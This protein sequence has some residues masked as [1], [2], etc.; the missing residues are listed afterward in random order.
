MMKRII[1]LGAS[2][3]TLALPIIVEMLRAACGP[4]ELLAAH[5]HG[6]SFGMGSRL[7]CR[8]LPSIRSCRLWRDL[9]RREPPAQRPW[10]LVTDVGNDLLYG[11]SPPQIRDWVATCLDRLE[12]Q[13]ADV[14]L[15]TLPMHSV[16]RLGRVRFG[17]T[18]ALFF[19][20]A[21]LAWDRM[22]ALA[23][24][25]DEGLR[26]LASERGVRTLAP[27]PE[28]YGFDP[29]H[30]RRRMRRRAWSHLLALE[31]SPARAV[32]ARRWGFATAVRIRLAR[33]AVRTVCGV[34]Q[35]AV[36]PVLCLPD[37]TTI[38]LY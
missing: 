30:I 37:G 1:L 4:V 35:Q 3:I 13:E 17:L 19:P 12:T 18:R 31:S 36:Q 16:L 7:L 2:N 9:A 24:E 32:S 34:R 38:S 26:A 23:Q 22:R 29:I 6:R 27:R 8:G 21:D 33:P 10:A 25:L 28:W 14:T 5:G 15:A 11:A 20:G